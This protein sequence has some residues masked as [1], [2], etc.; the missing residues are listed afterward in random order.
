MKFISLCFGT[1][2]DSLI[3]SF[4]GIYSRYNIVYL[5]VQNESFR[6]FLVICELW[7][8]VAFG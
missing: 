6:F 4:Y 1:V 7:F 5:C 2:Q 8:R 3:E